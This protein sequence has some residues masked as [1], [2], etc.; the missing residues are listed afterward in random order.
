MIGIGCLIVIIL[1]AILTDGRSTSVTI[2]MALI[3]VDSSMGSGEGEV[4][5]VM[6]EVGRFPGILAMTGSALGRVSGLGM[7]RVGGRIIIIDVTT[8][9]S[10]R[11][12]GVITGSM[13]SGTIGGDGG[14]GTGDYI[15]LIMYIKS[16]RRPTG[17][18]GVA[19]GTVIS[20]G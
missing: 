18:G 14:M 16:S 7:V 19:T 6:I 3:A 5:L 1:M 11:S 2:G 10:I 20:Q 13:A 12:V 4:G 9:T 17:L 8:G 15:V